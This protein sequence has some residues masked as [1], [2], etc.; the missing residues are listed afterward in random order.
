V[1]ITE[2]P[3]AVNKA[4]L[5]E[6]I[7]GLIAERKLP[8]LVDVRDESAEDIR[9][10]CDLRAEE[11]AESA[12]SYLCK[13][14]PLQ[15]NYHVNLTCLVPGDDASLPCVPMQANLRDVLRY[16]LDFRYATVER[17][18]RFELEKL[19]E[20]IHILEGFAILFD[21]LDEAIAIIRASE[22]RRDAHES[23][24][25]RFDLTDVQAEAI[26]DMQLYRITRGFILKLLAELDD[27]RARADEIA[28]ILASPAELWR[29][30]RE[31]LLEVRKEYGEKRRSVIL[32]EEAEELSFDE[33]DYIV[34]EDAFVIVTRDGWI[35]RQ[36]SFTEI[37]KIR[38]RD[39]DS[40]GWLSVGN[41]KATVTF[42]TDQGSAYTMRVDAVPATTGYGEPIQRHF[43][44]ADGE[45]VVGVAVHDRRSLP[46][47]SSQLGLP[48]GDDPPPP[49]AVAVSR[50]GRIVRLPLEPFIE[51]SNRTGRRFARLG[52]DGD[53]LVAAYVSDA[54]EQV[55]LASEQGRALTFPV[56]QANVLKGPGKGVMALKLETGD[57]VMGFTLSRSRMD[58]A[59]V[60]TSQGRDEVIRPN[61][62]E[63]N[64]AGKGRA[65]IRRGRF[66]TWHQ[67]LVRDD[68]TFAASEE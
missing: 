35:K 27:L 24:I 36:G 17:R 67:D 11:D 15:A 61:K 57:R 31:E 4:S 18:F 34:A 55:S 13:Y 1:V 43:K 64:R 29:V 47:G 26:L 2:I 37:D 58:G 62:F 16:W 6:K 38:T 25:D 44:F 28:R 53:R 59:R 23:L 41:T 45:T 65:V 30:V 9:I 54:T 52:G 12:M 50:E 32:G 7:G 8:Q 14:T 48:M 68:H 49:H 39:G 10:V 19:R 66:V 21:A 42:F 20:R 33:A 46:S 56:D 60:T 40:V 5:V 3:F 63:G 51:V 22:G